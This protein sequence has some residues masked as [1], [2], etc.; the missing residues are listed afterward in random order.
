M[1]PYHSLANSTGIADPSQDVNHHEQKSLSLCASSY[2]AT[3]NNHA[4]GTQDRLTVLSHY[5]RHHPLSFLL[6]TLEGTLYVLTEIDAID[7]QTRP[8][9]RS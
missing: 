7:T 6:L 2:N 3:K 4:T 5:S 8:I 9:H 1:V